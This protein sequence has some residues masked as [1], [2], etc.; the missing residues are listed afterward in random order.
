MTM[1]RDTLKKH[2]GKKVAKG[3]AVDVNGY[4]AGVDSPVLLGHTFFEVK[5]PTSGSKQK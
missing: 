3:I 2:M 4:T 1:I 5:K